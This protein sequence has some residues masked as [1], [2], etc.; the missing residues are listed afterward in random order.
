MHS[1][2][3][4]DFEIALR[5]FHEP[6]MAEGDFGYAY[7]YE[8]GGLLQRATKM[9]AEIDLPCKELEW[10]RA[11][12]AKANRAVKQRQQSASKVR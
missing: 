12:R 2:N 10:R 8:V 4:V 3:H 9:Q 11:T 5:E 1:D 6:A 7:W